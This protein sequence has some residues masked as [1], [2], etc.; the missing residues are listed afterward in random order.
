MKVAIVWKIAFCHD[1]HF[2]ARCLN[3]LFHNLNCS[4]FRQS[5]L[6][7]QEACYLDHCF[8]RTPTQWWNYRLYQNKDGS[9]TNSFLYSCDP[10]NQRPKACNSYAQLCSTD[11]KEPDSSYFWALKSYQIAFRLL[12][13][14]LVH[15]HE[16]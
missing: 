3:H 13:L 1:H 5:I 6:H 14:L 7:F 2:I 11:D 4:L 12:T 16:F 10:T 15:I 9:P 8:L